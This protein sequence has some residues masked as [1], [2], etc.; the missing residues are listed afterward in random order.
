MESIKQKAEKFLNEALEEN[1][2]LFM[3]EF[4]VN[5][6]SHIRVVI[7]GDGDVS[8]SD[9][10]AVSRKIEHQMDPENDDF[11]V[12]VTSSGVAQPLQMPRQ[13]IKNVGRS[14]EVILKDNTKLKA[15]LVTADEEKIE[16][17]W[18]AREPKPVGKGKTTV[19]KNASYKYNE[20]KEAK[21]MVI[22]NK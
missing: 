14:L 21:V 4:S 8:I 5:A 12:E 16:L 7:D 18:K 11:S 6:K 2:H 20:I 9:C 22:F 17:S 3:I 1:P 10:M 19:D 13:Y 15:E